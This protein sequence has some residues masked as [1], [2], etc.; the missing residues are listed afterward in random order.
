[1]SLCF[2]T[3]ESQQHFFSAVLPHGQIF[4]PHFSQN[5]VFHNTFHSLM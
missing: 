4:N 5:L 1:M 2:N 3:A